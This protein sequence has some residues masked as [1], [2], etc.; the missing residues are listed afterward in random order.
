MKRLWVASAAKGQVIAHIAVYRD[1]VYLTTIAFGPR[2]I[3]SQLVAMSRDN[4]KI[5]W[6]LDGDGQ[7]SRGGF[8]KWAGLP[9]HS[10]GQVLGR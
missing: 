8:Y 10:T 6:R 4:G 9:G 7:R 2:P 3:R 5:L 1:T